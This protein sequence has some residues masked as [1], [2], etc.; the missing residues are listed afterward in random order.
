MR[1][2]LFITA[3][4]LLA[5]VAILGGD[6]SGRIESCSGWALNRHP[7]LKMFLKGGEAEEYENVEV[8]YIHGRKA[9][10]YIY[11]DDVEI[12]TINLMELETRDDM[13]D[14]MVRKGFKKKS[15]EEY[16]D[17]IQDIEFEDIEEDDDDE[18]KKDEL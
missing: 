10:L 17:S 15:E 18:D 11:D 12:D 1:S 7:E 4:F 13:H 5:P 2:P 3:L 14:L 16:D 9:T 6:L 8:K